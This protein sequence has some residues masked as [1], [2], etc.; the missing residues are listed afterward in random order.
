M[1]RRCAR[2]LAIAVGLAALAQ[3]AAAQVA[4]EGLFGAQDTEEAVQEGEENVVRYGLPVVSEVHLDSFADFQ[5]FVKS[6][7]WSRALRSVAAQMED[8][9]R[10][11]LPGDGGIALS[12]TERLW[13]EMNALPRDGRRA[14]RVFYDPKAEQLWEE[15]H[16]AGVLPVERA[17]KLRLIYDVY[18]PTARG[19]DAADELARALL[20]AGHPQLAANHWRAVL[21]HHPDTDMDRGALWLTYLAAVAAAGDRYTFEEGASLIEL[22]YG[23]RTIDVG[24]RA[25]AVDAEVA[26]LRGE[27]PEA[28]PESRAE[29]EQS[30]LPLPATPEVGW[31][32]ELASYDMQSRHRWWTDET[33]GPR[34]AVAAAL[35]HRG[36][37]FLNSLGHVMAIDPATGDLEWELGEPPKGVQGVMLDG[38]FSILA[39]GERVVA[40]GDTE[41]PD[42][43]PQL[44]VLAL[45]L[46]GRVAWSTKARA[47]W[48]GVTAIGEPCAGDGVVYTCVQRL[49]NYKLLLRAL[50]LADGS[51]LFETDLGNPGSGAAETFFHS[52]AGEVLPISP[53]IT[54]DG[55]TLYVMTDSGALFAL[56]SGSGRIAWAFTYELPLTMRGVSR[57]SLAAAGG[58]LVFRS[59]GND[60]LFALDPARRE[61]RWSA[62]V[63]TSARIVAADERRVFLLSHEHTTAYALDTGELSWRRLMLGLAAHTSHVVLGP[64]H[65]YILTRRGLFELEKRQGDNDQA[66]VFRGAFTTFSSGDLL[67]TPEHLCC[68]SKVE[69]GAVPL[70]Q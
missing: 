42:G 31:R 27:I 32:V 59:Q 2:S 16:A 65:L 49:G 6:S 20:A 8:P 57:G 61:L 54:I 15:A 30:R 60:R 41:T 66:R 24:G 18:F 63:G 70:A 47:E 28:V 23:G 13:R 68:V 45:E 50:S 3:R 43:L 36:R 38:R 64:E 21:D 14:F 9:P 7:D 37:I 10:G 48:K 53:K 1:P 11:M 67:L 34:R 33:S 56:E 22:R 69:A 29:V 39:A 62:Q 4:P 19:D 58:M 44:H 51:L 17:A 46:D 5:D 12:W 55:E 52:S 35:A 25:V 26:R 40:T